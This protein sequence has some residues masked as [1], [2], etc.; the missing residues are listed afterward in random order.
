VSD[1]GKAADHFLAVAVLLLA[2]L[3][4]LLSLSRAAAAVA[5]Q[6]GNQGFVAILLQIMTMALNKK[7]DNNDVMTRIQ[8]MARLPSLSPPTPD[9][10][11]AIVTT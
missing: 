9:S 1:L 2:F 4:S 7:V 6:C 8:A 10:R 3:S 5:G 11:G